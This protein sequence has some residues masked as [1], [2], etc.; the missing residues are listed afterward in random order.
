MDPKTLSVCATVIK[1]L[2]FLNPQSAR[3]PSTEDVV[4]RF[5]GIEGSLLGDADN[6]SSGNMVLSTFA[7][8]QVKS[9]YVPEALKARQERQESW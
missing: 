3:L 4:R 9:E 7:V 5:A 2:P 1:S 8:A 6:E